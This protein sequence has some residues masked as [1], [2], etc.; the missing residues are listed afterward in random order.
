MIYQSAERGEVRS[1]LRIGAPSAPPQSSCGDCRVI[2][3]DASVTG[4]KN[5]Q[6][7]LGVE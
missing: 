2:G 5:R 7:P 3:N 6:N 4:P 1:S